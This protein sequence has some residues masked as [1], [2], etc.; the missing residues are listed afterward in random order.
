MTV[1]HGRLIDLYAQCG[2]FMHAKNALGSDYATQVEK[3][4]TKY[5]AAPEQIRKALTFM[6]NMLWQ[7]AVVQ[8]EWSDLDNPKEVSVPAA[9]W[10]IEFGMDPAEHVTVLVG[11]ASA[12]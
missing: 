8:L 6:K 9:A 4:R 12:P 3:E 7:H 5:A 1:S 2:G 11:E 10:I